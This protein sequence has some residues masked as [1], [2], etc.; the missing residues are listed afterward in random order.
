MKKKNIIILAVI[1]ALIILIIVGSI[2]IKVKEKSRDYYIEKVS[3]Y[4]YFIAKEN[5]LYGVINNRGEKIIETKYENVKIPNPSKEAFICYN[6]D[7]VVVLNEKNE[8][9][10]SQYEKVEPL[11]L[12]NVSSDLMYEKSILKYSKDG[13]FGIIDINGKKI[14]DAIY[15]DIDTLQ[16][17]EG[18]LLVKINNR[19]G[20]INIKGTILV[21]AEYDKI[22]A[23]RFYE[24][25]TAYKNGGYIV[26]KT[27]EDGY[28]K[29]YVNN[30]G[31]EIVSTKY[32]DLYR[33]NEIN[34]SDIYLICAENGKYGISKNG[35][36][37]L[38]NEYQSIE[39]NNNNTFVALKGKKY[40]VISIDGKTIVPFDYKQID[41][42]GNYIYATSNNENVTVFD[43]NGKETDISEQTA[44]ID[45]PN[46]N[47]QIHMQVEENQTLYNIYENNNKITKSKYIYIEYL[48]DNYFMCCNSE[49]RLGIIDDKE[50]I[51]V[52]FKYNS[53][54]KIG[55][56]QL[57]QTI[58][59]NT[60]VTEIY[61]NTMNKITELKDAKIE[62]KEEY[63]KL[64]NENDTK[65]ITKDG[66]ELQNTDI[67][68]ENS[69][70]AQE[71]KNKWG[72]VDI[73]GNKV[74][75]YKYDKVTE[76]NKYGFAGI[77]KDKKWGVIDS[78]GNIIV[79]P[80]YEL[81]DIEPTF[82]GEYYQVIYGNGEIYYTK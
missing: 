74:V 31:K 79:E 62:D 16:F 33:V 8:E 30:K 44:I 75:D 61:S 51:K 11:R 42:T 37:I 40:G 39:Y 45:I 69:I 64:Y 43:S 81:S 68:S 41:I 20:V 47:Y 2:A 12:K 59:N 49:G 15:E 72:F 77:M 73:S 1:I 34:T 25:E 67:F 70:F 14:T 36:S 57:I 9:I 4:K 53:I 22:E 63:I 56:T 58:N 23:D 7:S 17:K 82:I 55:S 65:Y 13:K 80:K 78:K 60:K 66:R 54:Q 76:L 38:N 24:E 46:T 19:Y 71:F 52:E 26:S 6:G 21:K 28:R 5:N 29:G 48:Y 3:E 27:T 35:K 18:E 32:N 10:F 50:N